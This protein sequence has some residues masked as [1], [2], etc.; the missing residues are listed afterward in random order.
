MAT[1]ES[2]I[3]LMFYCCLISLNGVNPSTSSGLVLKATNS[4][5]VCSVVEVHVDI[6]A[7]EVEVERIGAANRTAPIAAPGTDKGERTTT[8]VAVAPH[9][10]LKC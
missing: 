6:A 3:F 8:D 4:E 5:T 2:S 9:G 1:S 10:Q 7:V